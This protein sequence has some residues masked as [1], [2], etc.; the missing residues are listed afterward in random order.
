MRIIE[1]NFNK[2][3]PIEYFAECLL[4]GRTRK[5]I[6]SLYPTR[7]DGAYYLDKFSNY[8]WDTYKITLK[9]YIKKFCE[10][11]YPKFETGEDLGFRKTGVGIVFSRY[12]R[13]KVNKENCE[14]FKKG[15][16]KLSG[17]RKGEG[18]PMFGK[19]PWNKDSEEFSIWLSK[20]KK[21]VPLTE[22]HKKKLSES[23]KKRTIHGHTGRKHSEESKEKMRIATAK[24]FQDGSFGKRS[25][26]QEKVWD[27]LCLCDLI[28]EPKEEFFFKYFSLD[29][30]FEG[31]KV[32][33]EVQGQ[34]FHVDPRFYPNG[35]INAVQRRNFGRDKAKKKILERY[36][37][38]L[39]EVWEK[40][41]NDESY[42]KE[43]ICKL[44]KLGL[45]NPS[46]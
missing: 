1:T 38:E 2:T 46:A 26:I 25:N 44:Q 18:N 31:A 40:E 24:R 6:V 8:L 45:L 20:Q 15:C 34:F 19:T 28:E 42:Q 12:I 37:W 5:E 7:S 9:D 10:D 29:F 11:D 27:F 23:A 35:P 14:K 17:E 22:A 39:I 41:I 32:A 43:L 36:G 30:A 3:I 33:I 21:G 4:D 13:G 16:E